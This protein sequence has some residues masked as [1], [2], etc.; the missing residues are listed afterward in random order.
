[1]DGF[2]KIPLAVVGDPSVIKSER[3]LGFDGQRSCVIR[4]GII[5]ATNFVIGKPAIEQ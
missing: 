3:I 1:M 4:N 5:I 2:I